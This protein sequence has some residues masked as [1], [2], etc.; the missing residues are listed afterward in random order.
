MDMR[1]GESF[2]P[3]CGGA[4]IRPDNRK[5]PMNPPIRK[6][7]E[8]LSAVGWRCAF[9][10]QKGLPEELLARYPWLP[11]DVTETLAEL[12]EAVHPDDTLWL[13]TAADYRSEGDA[14]FAWNEWEVLSVEAASP[15][16]AW[17]AEIRTFWDG[18][19]PVALSVGDGYG[20]YAVTRD[21]AVVFGEEPEF[22]DTVPFA[23]SYG[24][25]IAR[26]SSMG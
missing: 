3:T 15:D 18:H 4:S 25:F 12:Q 1:N 16:E 23:G 20:Y 13:L 9:H 22:E 2:P 19:F 14:E 7:L 5:T 10:T 21:G 17:M 24:E 26:L 6:A 8:E 11:G